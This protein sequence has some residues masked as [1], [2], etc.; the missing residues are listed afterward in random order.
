MFSAASLMPQ[1][2]PAC[3]KPE[4]ELCAP[5]HLG[6]PACGPLTQPSSATLHVHVHNCMQKLK[7]SQTLNGNLYITHTHLPKSI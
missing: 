4:E 5:V 6:A 1:A 3:P 7:P 2:L